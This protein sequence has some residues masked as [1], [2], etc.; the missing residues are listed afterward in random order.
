[1]SRLS[2]NSV[3]LGLSAV[4]L[5]VLAFLFGSATHSYGWVPSSTLEGAWKQLDALTSGN[6]L[7]FLANK[8]FDRSGVRSVAPDR[9]QDG[10][11]LVSSMW[12]DGG[13]WHTALRMLDREGAVVHEWSPTAVD[14]FEDPKVVGHSGKK[15]KWANIGEYSLDPET[16]EVVVN[17]AYVGLAKLDACGEPIW[18]LPIHTHHAVNRADDGSYWAPA[19]SSERH[20]NVPDG[21]PTLP[22]FEGRDAGPGAYYD[23]LVHVSP[24]GEVLH[25]INVFRVLYENDLQRHIF[26]TYQARIQDG[27]PLPG[28]ITHVNDVEPLG[29]DMADSYPQFDAGDVLVSARNLDLVFVLDP[30]SLR[31]K[32]HASEP[33][34]EQH[35]PDFIGDGRIGVFDNN[36]DGSARGT[37]LGG[38]RIVQVVPATGEVDVLFPTAQSETFYTR[39]GGRWQLLP[40]GNRLLTETKTGRVLEVDEDGSTVWEWIHE[41]HDGHA[42]EVVRAT[43]HDLTEREVE[44]WECSAEGS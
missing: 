23:R 1:M 5:L 2:S 22:G 34:I 21:G 18:R 12:K 15:V 25:D 27:E 43:R 14:I 38:S 10:T 40:N 19:S 36:R 41:P 33:F 16:G 44:S 8:R 4:G 24:D 39:V 31:V 29:A 42:I 7:H 13:S 9:M 30:E 26:K 37:R 35:D 11:T 6:R 17:F 32:W 28:D 20:R 3:Q